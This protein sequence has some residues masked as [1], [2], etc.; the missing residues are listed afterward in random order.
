MS[1]DPAPPGRPAPRPWEVDRG[2]LVAVAAPS[3]AGKTTLCVRMAE[4][5]PAL[6]YAVSYTTRPPRPGEVNGRNYHFVAPERFRAM[7][8][9]GAFLEWA[10]VHGHFYGTPKVGVM[11]L[12]ATG[13]DVLL[14]LDVQGVETIKALGEPGVFCLILPPSFEVLRRRLEERGKDSPADIDRRMTIAVKELARFALFDYVIVN[15][16]LEEAARAL[17]GIIR[18]E[19][20]RRTR[21]RQD[22]FREHFVP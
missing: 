7:V 20:A 21:I 22:W 14:D 1:S 19:H 5:F 9:A 6:T 4:V 16:E 15:E 8:S 13:H 3:G 17:E 12:L 11:D 18:A 2:L 10:E